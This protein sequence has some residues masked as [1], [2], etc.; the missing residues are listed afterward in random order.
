MT[1]NTF[2]S[3]TYVP[4]EPY[5][6]KITTDVIRLCK[7]ED[8]INDAI[9]QDRDIVRSAAVRAYMS[10]RLTFNTNDKYITQRK[11]EL[12]RQQ[13]SKIV[14]NIVDILTGPFEWKDVEYSRYQI[15]RLKKRC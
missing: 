11:T 2:F 8:Y 6:S 1:L 14:N 3:C 13:Y 15:D 7:F 4:Y 12:T 10:Q 5:E 9:R